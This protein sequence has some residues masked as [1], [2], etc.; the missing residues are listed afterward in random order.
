MRMALV[1]IVGLAT[2]VGLTGAEKAGVK[3]GPRYGVALDLAAYPQGKPQETLAS[4]LKAVENKRLDYV[5]AQLSDPAFIDARVKTFGGRFADQ[6]EDTRARL[7]PAT[8]KLLQ[9]FLKDGEWRVADKEAMVV[10]KDMKDRFLFLEKNGDRWFLLHR[11]KAARP[12]K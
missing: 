6:V 3:D 11:S 1:M 2:A 9:R 8:V 10:L 5:V 12:V 4:V 7:D